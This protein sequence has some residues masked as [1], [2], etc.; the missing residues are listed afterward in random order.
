VPESTGRGAGAA[1]RRGRRRLPA[2]EPG[3][4]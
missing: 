2:R 1:E 4:L 3:A